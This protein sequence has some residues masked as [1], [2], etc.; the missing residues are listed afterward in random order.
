MNLR[1][2]SRTLVNSASKG[3]FH[4]IHRIGQ[5]LRLRHPYSGSI[6]WESE[7][8]KRSSGSYSTWSTFSANRADVKRTSPWKSNRRKS[9]FRLPSCPV[10]KSYRI[11][12][13][14]IK[15]TELR[16]I[17][18]YLSKSFCFYFKVKKQDFSIVKWSRQ[19]P[20]FQST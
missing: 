6:G 3:F 7:W 17:L 15:R 12:I 16:V 20:A 2:A 1:I 18:H 5:N 11:L 4:K 13:W 10:R 9:Y 8:I 19:I 14:P